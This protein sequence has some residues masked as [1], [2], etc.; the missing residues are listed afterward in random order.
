MFVI[1]ISANQ[2]IQKGT[3]KRFLSSLIYEVIGV[4]CS[5]ALVMR[6]AV[7]FRVDFRL[8]VL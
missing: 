1:C 3:W 4:S 5:V 6:L 7:I 8:G 2:S